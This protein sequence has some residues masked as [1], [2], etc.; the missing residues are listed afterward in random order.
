ML[1]QTQVATVI[2][3]YERFLRRFPDVAALAE[4]D[5]EEVLRLWAGLG[6]YRR[7]RNL[8]RAARL[9]CAKHGKFPEE[10]EA[11][12]ALPGIGDYTAG[13][14]CSI[15]L[16]QPYPAVDGNVKRIL[17][18]VYAVRGKV[19]ESFFQ[20]RARALLPEKPA[21]PEP[22]G[23]EPASPEKDVASFN[24]ALMDLGALV[25]TPQKPQCGRCPIAGWCAARKL[26]LQDSLPAKAASREPERLDIVLLVLERDGEGGNR[27]VLLTSAEKPQIIPGKLGLPCRVA[28]GGE[29]PAS[30][31][32]G[33]CRETVGDLPALRPL[34]KFR[35]SITHHRITAHVFYGEQVPPPL[36][37]PAQQGADGVR[38][39]AR[40]AAA[41]ELVSSLFHKALRYSGNI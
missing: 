31:A 41:T 39:T 11:I 3:Y 28:P 6:Y 30:T 26:G 13:A 40:D 33:L 23:P 9:A 12:R 24:Q 32:A 22:A 5:E 14:I 15:A 10:F 2:P 8:L 27:E 35:H 17:T 20:K 1:Q 16:H 7:A 25:C 18:R 37:S 38:W 4:A 36:A 29:P 19:P 34:K 21:S